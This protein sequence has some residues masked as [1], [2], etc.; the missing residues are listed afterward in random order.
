MSIEMTTQSLRLAPEVHLP[1]VGFGAAQLGNLYRETTDEESF[2]AIDTAW[3]LGVRYFDTAPHYGLG[4][5]ERRVGAALAVRS[6]SDY[7]LST[8]VGRVLVESPNT[9]HQQDNHGFVVPANIRRVLDYSY[10]GV[11]RSIEDSLSRLGTDYIDIAYLH[12]PDRY[13][14]QAS[15]GGVAALTSLRDQGVIRAWGAG[16]NQSSM[17]ARFVTE[18]GADVVMCAGRYT[19]LEQPALDDLL[20][21]AT[22]TGAGVVIAGVYNSGLLA[23]ERVADNAS[24]DYQQAAPE[25]INR[26]QAIAVACEKYGVSLPQA[27]LAFVRGHVS[28]V[29]TVVGLRTAS[30]VHSTVERMAVSIPHELWYELKATG[31]LREDAPVPAFADPLENLAV[32][33]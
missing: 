28:V 29:S 5:S 16:M 19:L 17:L 3:E 14:E 2:K 23:H 9:A 25:L 4:L 15:T 30:H 32:P 20:P 1:A 10:D 22:A 24:Y 8:K 6:R 11:M 13:W 12:D 18:A 21:A 33:V 31:L 26:A 27:A 7:V